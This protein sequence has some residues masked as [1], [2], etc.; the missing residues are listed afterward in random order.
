MAAIFGVIGVA[1]MLGS[2]G[3]SGYDAQKQGAELRKQLQEVQANNAKLDALTKGLLA[4]KYQMSEELR[5]EIQASLEQYTVLKQRISATKELYNDEFRKL[6]LV[7]IVI[8]AIVF[9]SLVI[10]Q[11]GFVKIIKDVL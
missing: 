10:K 6:E 8:L 4:S 9:F 5:I 2:L 7:G 1:G 3:S 11:F